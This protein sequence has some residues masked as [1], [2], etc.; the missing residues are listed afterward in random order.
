MYAALL[1]TISISLDEPT[2]RTKIISK[3]RLDKSTKLYEKKIDLYI[4]S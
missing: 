2:R 1:A 3:Y 4:P